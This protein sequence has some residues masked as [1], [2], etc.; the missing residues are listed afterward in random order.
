MVGE[1]LTIVEMT[2]NLLPA[3]TFEGVGWVF[4]RSTPELA[5]FRG[6]VGIGRLRV[7]VSVRP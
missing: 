4:I 7:C 6:R 1:L 3:F 2:S 5:R